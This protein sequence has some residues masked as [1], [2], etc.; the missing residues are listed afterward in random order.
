MSRN[1][2]GIVRIGLGHRWY[3][4]YG[5]N[6]GWFRWLPEWGQRVIV[7]CWN[8]AICCFNGHVPFTDPEEPEHNVPCL[9]CGKDEAMT[10]PAVREPVRVGIRVT[11]AVCGDVKKPIGRSAHAEW[12]GCDDQC[13]GYRQA[14]FPGSLWPGER[15][16][17]FGFP[18]SDDGTELV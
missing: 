9:H 16:D 7:T 11:C 15:S 1:R 6:H 13:S 12:F 8:R 18:V 4:G 5:S 10:P 3:L 17:D 2:S 14:P